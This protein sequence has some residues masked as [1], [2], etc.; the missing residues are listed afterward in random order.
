[1]PR[2]MVGLLAAVV[3]AMPMLAVL[4]HGALFWLILAEATFA[5]GLAAFGTAP[6]LQ[7]LKKKLTPDVTLVT[8]SHFP[9]TAA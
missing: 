3:T 5:A 4:A 6:V 1:M 8:F 2:S 7:P 9:L